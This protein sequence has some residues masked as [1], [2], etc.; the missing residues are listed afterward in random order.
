[1]K[2]YKLLPAIVLLSVVAAAFAIPR[3]IKINAIECKSQFGPCSSEVSDSLKTHKGKSLSAAKKQITFSLSRNTTVKDFSVRFK[4]PSTLAVIILEA[5]A[6]FA[7][8]G[9]GI[10]ANLNED[11]EVLSIGDDTALPYVVVPSRPP[12][13]GEKV[14]DNILFAL[15]IQERLYSAY[16]VRTGKIQ[17]DNFKVVLPDGVTVLFPLTGDLDHILGALA[18]II[19]ELKRGAEVSRIEQ[20]IS[21]IDLRFANPVLR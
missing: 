2:I 12:N 11:G 9:E 18:L 14:D 5:K 15:K 6:R 7:V 17:G 19:Y 13:L 16:Q 8:M 10:Y 4:L 21:T 20:T 1:M 3:T